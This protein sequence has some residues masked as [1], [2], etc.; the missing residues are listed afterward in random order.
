MNIHSIHFGSTENGNSDEGSQVKTQDIPLIQLKLIQAATDNFSH[1]NK[2]GQG[3]FGPVYK[4][5][6]F[7]ALSSFIEHMQMNFVI[8]IRVYYSEAKKYLSR[9]FHIDQDKE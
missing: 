2:L 8:C 4:V 7:S 5:Q 1:A 6:T 3:G 9:G